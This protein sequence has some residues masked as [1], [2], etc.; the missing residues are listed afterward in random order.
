ME[1]SARKGGREMLFEGRIHSDMCISSAVLTTVTPVARSGGDA[2]PCWVGSWCTN[3]TTAPEPCLPGTYNPAQYSTSPDACIPCE[4][5][6]YCPT[7]RVG[8]PADQLLK[9]HAGFYCTGGDV[10]PKALVCPAGGY[11]EEGSAYPTACD[12][13]TYA[14]YP[15][16]TNVSDCLPCPPGYY[17]QYANSTAPTGICDGGWYCS[18]GSS[19]PQP[20]LGSGMGVCVCVACRPAACVRHRHCVS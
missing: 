3:G 19:S 18:G 12:A 17:C 6:R 11:C 7:E 4:P 14:P 9:C 8:L 1:E 15:G 10:S 5:G 13:G 20:L 2:G 16:N